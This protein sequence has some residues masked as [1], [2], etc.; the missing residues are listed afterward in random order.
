MVG[1]QDIARWLV[2]IAAS[3]E[4]TQTLSRSH[5]MQSACNARPQKDLK[6]H[7]VRSRAQ[8]GIEANILSGDKRRTR[9]ACE[10]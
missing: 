2:S 5:S 1:L 10:S 4:A 9:P 8:H 6:L 3:S 7:G